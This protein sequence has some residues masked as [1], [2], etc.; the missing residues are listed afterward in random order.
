[1]GVGLREVQPVVQVMLVELM[2]VLVVA[3]VVLGP[4]MLELVGVLLLEL[5]ELWFAS[6]GGPAWA[7]V[8]NVVEV[9]GVPH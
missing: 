3:V 1:M 6:F 7:L 9:G 4:L 8:A 2:G 5:V